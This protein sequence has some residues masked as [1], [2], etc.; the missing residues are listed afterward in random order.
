MKKKVLLFILVCYL[1]VANAQVWEHFRDISKYTKFTEKSYKIIKDFDIYSDQHVLLNKG[2]EISAFISSKFAYM[3]YI[4]DNSCI[5]NDYLV[6]YN[7]GWISVDDLV[8]ENS[9]IFLDSML[10]EKQS[11]KTWIPVWYNSI[12]GKNSN[13]ESFS[14]YYSRYKGSPEYNLIQLH[15]LELKNT[16]LVLHDTNDFWCFSIKNLEKVNNIYLLKCEIAKNMQQY[17]N[18]TLSKESLNNLPNLTENRNCTFIIEQNGNRLR[19]YNGENYK[20]IIELMQTDNNWNNSMLKYIEADYK[21][22]PSNLTPIEEKLDHPWSD[23]K[24]GLYEG[25]F[26]AKSLVAVQSTNVTPNKTMLVTENL[27][28][29]SGEATTSDVLT[30]MSAGT[31]VKIL[32]LGKTETID[33]I[34]SN[35]VKVEVQKGAK[36]RDGRAIRAGTVGWCY[37]GYLK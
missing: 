23:P 11:D 12:C 18:E 2:Y 16:L 34:S 7:N 20:L 25:T 37:G 22:K 8:L 1:G 3:Y 29:R 33:G 31:K 9:D 6:P 10:S 4:D 24:T 13:L 28:L 17:F 36:D 32:E 26:D 30:V 14:N 35:W 19:L 5:H 15:K 21:N 27:K